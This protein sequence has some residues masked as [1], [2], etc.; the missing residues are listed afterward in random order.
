MSRIGRPR[1]RVIVIAS[2]YPTG[3][4]QGGSF[5]QD[6]VA[7]LAEDHEVAVIAPDLRRFRSLVRADWLKGRAPTLERGVPVVRP[8]ITPP[9][10]RTKDLAL[11]LYARGVA[12]ALRALGPDWRRPDVIHAHVV[13]PGGFAAARLGSRLEIPVVLTEHSGPFSM[14]LAS[15]TDRRSVRWT[16]ANMAQVL[17]VGPGLARDIEHFA[18]GTP[19]RVL[20]NV[21]DTDFFSPGAT[22]SD[23]KPPGRAVRVVTVSGL[24]P[25][26]GL[27]TLLRALALLRDRPGVAMPLVAIIGDGRQ[28]SDLERLAQDLGVAGMCCFVGAQGRADVRD[29]LR[30]AELFVLPSHAETFSVATAEAMACGTPVIV[31]RS[32]GPDHFVTGGAG[33]VVESGDPESLANALARVAQ[34]EVALDGAEARR[35]IVER[36]SR[37]AFLAAMAS[38][39]EAVVARTEPPRPRAADGAAGT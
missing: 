36:F 15:G 34:G 9:V 1:R 17:A 13:L 32:G 11:G 35:I 21:V 39:Y 29:W 20:G 25:G 38:V 12:R 37:A 19:V 28:R 16:L 4:S 18:P 31:T 33:V 14:H 2:W 5:V 8:V 23:E 10:P 3:R 6:Q 24:L 22:E 27:D 26:K 7:A 30:W